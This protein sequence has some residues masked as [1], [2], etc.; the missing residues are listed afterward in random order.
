[1]DLSFFLLIFQPL[2]GNQPALHNS[3]D[4]ISAQSPGDPS[5]LQG[6]DGVFVKRKV[7]GMSKPQFKFFFYSSIGQFWIKIRKTKKCQVVLYVICNK[8]FLSCS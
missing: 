1:M 7:P 4:N 5:H 2:A 3:I 6:H 8:I